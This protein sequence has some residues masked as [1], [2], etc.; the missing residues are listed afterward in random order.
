VKLAVFEPMAPGPLSGNEFCGIHVDH[1]AFQFRGGLSFVGT[2]Q[3][4]G[5]ECVSDAEC[6]HCSFAVNVQSKCYN[7]RCMAP[8]LNWVSSRVMSSVDG[9]PYHAAQAHLLYHTDYS[10]NPSFLDW[11]SMMNDL[12]AEEVFLVNE[13][14]ETH[15]DSCNRA[16][17]HQI[18]WARDWYAR[19]RNLTIVKASGNISTIEGCTPNDDAVVACHSLNSLCVGATTRGSNSDTVLD[20]SD[21]RVWEFSKWLNPR[22]GAAPATTKEAERP[23]VVT[24][25]AMA[26]VV[27]FFDTDAWQTVSGTSFAAP[28]L[29]GQLA[30]LTGKCGQLGP[31]TNR[32]I[33]RTFAYVRQTL[34]GTGAAPS[35]PVPGFST[36]SRSG[37]GILLDP[38]Y[39]HL[40]GGPLLDDPGAPDDS[41]FD[42]GTLA[43]DGMAWVDL[44][45]WT[46]SEG[47]SGN[48]PVTVENWSSVPGHNFAGQPLRQFTKGGMWMPLGQPRPTAEGTRLRVTFSFSTCPGASAS[49]VPVAGPDVAPA[50]DF[51]LALCSPS[52]KVCEAVSESKDDT[53]EGFDVVIS[54]NYTDLT[55]FLVRPKDA[56]GCDPSSNAEPYGL[57]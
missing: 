32:A 14:T 55:L 41:D 5:P 8:H 54:N 24:E 13:S 16:R 19:Y 12:V 31:N 10:G 25:G 27:D 2:R 9:T 30:I 52:Q 29:A 39:L 28:V 35:Y 22:F 26:H 17:Y 7:Q 46:D 43:L 50:V 33:A 51:D 18:D 38:T 56:K 6:A 21:D 57:A 48:N 47:P 53:N 40:C 49:T 34:E 36:D 37:A 23:D 11:V 44:P 15:R 20:F 3:P 1:E 42:G 4:G 45:P